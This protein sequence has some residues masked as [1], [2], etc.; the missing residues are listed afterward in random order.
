MMTD[1]APSAAALRIHRSRE[2][3]R[4]G[5]TVVTIELRAAEIATLRRM[6]L[7]AEAD[8]GDPAAIAKAL[9]R[10]LDRWLSPRHP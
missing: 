7:L 6:G 2:R 1:K 10:L 5:L 3:R 4:N 9:G 8:A